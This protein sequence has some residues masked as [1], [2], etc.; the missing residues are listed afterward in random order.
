MNWT[1][2][3]I[4][5]YTGS[6]E[7]KVAIVSVGEASAVVRDTVNSLAESFKIG[8][9]IVRLLRPWDAERFVASIPSS[10]IER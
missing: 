5:E 7:A 1:R 3:E 8:A 10:G 4:F 6:P 2:Y 9:I